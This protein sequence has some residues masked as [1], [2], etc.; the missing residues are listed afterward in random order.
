MSIKYSSN[1][2]YIMI[3][4]AL[5]RFDCDAD[6]FLILKYVEYIYFDCKGVA[7][8]NKNEDVFINGK[9]VVLNMDE[10][11][12]VVY[13]VISDQKEYRRTDCVIV[14]FKMI[15][16]SVEDKKF[17]KDDNN[18]KIEIPLEDL[19]V[20]CEELDRFV[21]YINGYKK[22]I[23]TKPENRGIINSLTKE[24]EMLK[25][26]LTII[27]LRPDLVFGGNAKP[28]PNVIDNLVEYNSKY[29]FPKTDGQSL[30]KSSFL[31]KKLNDCLKKAREN[32]VSSEKF[33]DHR[34]N[35]S[36]KR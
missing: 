2:R 3:V 27:M 33:V 11:L 16:G 28:T 32:K 4:D 25:A 7:K 22:F 8:N 9:A 10:I 30:R 13:D 35:P 1:E 29:L 12:G 20:E 23:N 21:E 24:I 18:Y 36:E 14:D 6:Y 17:P 19:Y 26:A 5:L 15:E 34:G 31:E